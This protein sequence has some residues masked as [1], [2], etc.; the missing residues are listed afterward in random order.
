M[1]TKCLMQDLFC[2]VLGTVVKFGECCGSQP[3]QSMR[4][5]LES[6]QSL[7]MRDEERE[8]KHLQHLGGTALPS[9][10]MLASVDALEQL[11]GELTLVLST[12]YPDQVAG[13]SLEEI[14]YITTCLQGAWPVSRNV[15]SCLQMLL[16]DC[17]W[18]TAG[19]CY[20]FH[21]RQQ[22]AFFRDQLRSNP[23]LLYRPCCLRRPARLTQLPNPQSCV[24]GFECMETTELAHGQPTSMLQDIMDLTV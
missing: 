8:A 18:Q 10:L 15:W 21:G 9:H 5:T 6:L 20:S 7:L 22:P 13:I 16:I 12:L 23:I 3:C 19:C 1:L 17:Y 11:G 24:Q 2:L 14:D 4:S